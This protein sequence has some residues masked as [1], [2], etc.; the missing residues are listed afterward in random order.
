MNT[1]EKAAVVIPS[2]FL[3]LARTHLRGFN[4]VT[5]RPRDLLKTDWL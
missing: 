2:L 3:L 4:S 5:V 1:M